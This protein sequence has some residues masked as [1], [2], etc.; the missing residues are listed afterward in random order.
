MS[1]ETNHTRENEEEDLPAEAGPHVSYKIL[2]KER[3]DL[4]EGNFLWTVSVEASQNGQ[5]AT[6]LGACNSNEKTGDDMLENAVLTTAHQRAKNDALKNLTG[7]TKKM[8]GKIEWKGIKNIP[9]SKARLNREFR[10]A[11]REKKST[12]IPLNMNAKE[13]EEK[14]E[15]LFDKLVKATQQHDKHKAELL[16]EDIAQVRKRKRVL[17]LAEELNDVLSQPKP[18]EG[19]DSYTVPNQG[20]IYGN[21]SAGLMWVFHNRILPIKIILDI[22]A[23]QIIDDR[24]RFIDF[25]ELRETVKERIEILTDYIHESDLDLPREILEKIGRRKTGFPH[26]AMT[27][28]ASP[29]MKNY[30]DEDGALNKKLGEKKRKAGEAKLDSIVTSSKSRFVDQFLGR[31]L[32]G[33]RQ[34]RDVTYVGACF[35]MGLLDA[36]SYENGALVTLTQSGR[37]FV[38][39]DNPVIQEIFYNVQANTANR[40]LS[41]EEVEFVMKNIIST[42]RFELE[43]RMI[44]GILGSKNNLIIDDIEKMLEKKQ[45]AYLKQNRIDIDVI[46]KNIDSYRQQRAIATASRLVEMGLLEKDSTENFKDGKKLP[47]KTLYVITEL[48]REWGKRI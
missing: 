41:E 48:G 33:K 7:R 26:T 36:I 1:E 35:E 43:D 25:E 4:G 22:V 42:R 38:C 10:V 28:L 13:L 45:A 16:S 15:E 46:K 31:E 21:G 8:E 19:G 34:K 39:M 3:I 17:S 27:A 23:R 2:N 20:E 6:G 47:P 5:T 24:K 40:I 32:G 12:L 9:I 44:A 29:R 30:V 37:D 18:A 14:D 11:R